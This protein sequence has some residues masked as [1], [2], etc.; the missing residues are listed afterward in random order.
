MESKA[1]LISDTGRTFPVA[2]KKKKKSISTEMAT[3]KDKF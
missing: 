3:G 1:H 2:L